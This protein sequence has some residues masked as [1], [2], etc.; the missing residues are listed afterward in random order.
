MPVQLLTIA[1]NAFVESIRQPI[2][3]VLVLLAMFLQVMSTW[4]AA[5]S[6]GYSDSAEVSGDNKLLL[7]YGLGA[8]FVFGMLLAA[9]TATSVISREIE[10]RTI[11]TVVSKPVPR[12]VVVVGKFLGVAATLLVGVIIMLATLL[13]CIR[14]GVLSTAAD[15]PDQPVIVFGLCALGIALALGVWGNYM[16]G[17]Y[18][19]QTTLITLAPL[20]VVAY[21]LVLLVGKKWEWQPMGKD[22]KPQIMVAC[23]VLTMGILVLAA[24]ATAISTRVSQVM[25]IVF[26]AGLFLLGLLSNYLFGRHAMNN[27]VIGQVQSAAPAAPSDEGFHTSGAT[28]VVTLQNPPRTTVKAGAPFYYSVSPY[29]F[30]MEFWSYTPF[31]GDPASEA[32]LHSAEPALIISAVAGR[33][34]TV[35]NIGG[36]PVDVF[37]PPAQG[38]YVFI[39]PTSFHPVYLA[40]W[41]V[42]PNLQHFWLLDAVSQNRLVPAR[43]V[44]LVGLYA[45]VQVTA[46]LCLGVFLFQKRDVG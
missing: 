29:G 42:I 9:F 1:R 8:V 41:G 25:T 33:I 26:C 44:A 14:H 23:A 36:S 21:L 45:G 30:P 38:D 46:F 6:M 3:F 10:R 28:Y 37:R 32:A 13:L 11:L 16:Y 43:H 20:L 24:A 27:T 31:T 7:D 39:Q 15:D 18:F 19:S 34:I 22:F 4:Y 5:Y 35:R 40:I 12:A 2:V 17:W